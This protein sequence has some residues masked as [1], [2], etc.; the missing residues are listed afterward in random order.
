M[1]AASN[2]SRNVEKD[3]AAAGS[4]PPAVAAAAGKARAGKARGGTGKKL[5]IGII[6]GLVVLLIAA[7]VLWMKQYYDYNYALEDNYYV[8]VPLDWDVM[9]YDALDDKGNVMGLK[10]SYE[11]TGYS[12]DG[13]AR[14]LQFDVLLDMH[15]LYP[16]GTYIQVSASKRGVTSKVALDESQVPAAALALLKQ[17][18]KPSSAPTL[19]AYAE[20]RSR[21]LSARNTPSVKLSCELQESTL[22][23]SYVYEPGAR[24]MAEHDAKYIS[25]IYKAQFRTDKQAF[26]ELT[27]VFLEVKLADGTVILSEKHDTVV[28]FGYEQK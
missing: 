15:D 7:G 28:R 26:P 3:V 21:Q 18:F 24:G 4:A 2:K 13:K 14:D 5:V 17:G 8:V 27:A 25:P 20:E 10:A 12:A 16:P 19:A 11:L 22:V 6:V 1:A 9:P 23:Y